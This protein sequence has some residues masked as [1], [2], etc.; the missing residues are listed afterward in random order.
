MKEDM[1]ALPLFARS[2]LPRC[3]RRGSQKARLSPVGFSLM[4]LNLFSISGLE[5]RVSRRSGPFASSPSAELESRSGVGSPRSIRIVNFFCRESPALRR[6]PFART[7]P[8]SGPGP[9]PTCTPA[10][11]HQR[12]S[13]C[14]SYELQVHTL[15]QARLRF[16]LKIPQYLVLLY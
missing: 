15:H 14:T 3:L 13:F 5:S 1:T 9:L 6:S 7:R 12:M 16:S 4:I 8:V 10:I 2:T 11:G